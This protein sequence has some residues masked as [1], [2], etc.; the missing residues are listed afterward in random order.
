MF[1]DFEYQ[2]CFGPRLHYRYSK[3]V[4]YFV[5]HVFDEIFDT[6]FLGLASSRFV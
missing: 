3:K 6:H 1:S 5:N 2:K 4:D